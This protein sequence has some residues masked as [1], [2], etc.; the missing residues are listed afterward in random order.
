[1]NTIVKTSA[2]STQGRQQYL[3]FTLKGDVFAIG[4][5]NIEEII[6][7]GQLTELP[8]MPLFIRGVIDLRGAA[9]PVVDLNACFGK[10]KSTITRR[11]CIVIVEV[12]H[13]D[14]TRVVGVLVDAVSAVLDIPADEIEP[15]PRFG[16][17]INADYIA[18]MAKVD[19]KFVVVL[20]IG[21]A[22]LSL[23]EVAQVV[24]RDTGAPPLL[25]AAA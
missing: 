9:V 14:E 18:G 3:T 22:V 13:A 2:D 20:N 19:G 16:S 7:Y 12:A 10:E 1:M 24:T 25:E 11:S 5:L 17:S 6:E 8:R 15:A 4:I 21:G 23:D